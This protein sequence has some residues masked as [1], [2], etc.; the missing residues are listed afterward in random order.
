MSVTPKSY[1]ERTNFLAIE[2]KM[3]ADL[4]ESK[5]KTNSKN[6]TLNSFDDENMDGDVFCTNT[7]R[8]I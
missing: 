6:C 1:Q 2:P 3:F 7:R 8:I 5:V 4:N